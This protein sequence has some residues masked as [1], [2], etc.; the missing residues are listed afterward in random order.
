MSVQTLGGKESVSGELDSLRQQVD[1]EIAQTHAEH[2]AL[3]SF[4]DRLT[5][6]FELAPQATI[7]SSIATDSPEEQC[8]RSRVAE[9]SSAADTI[10]A[11]RR[12]YQETVMGL[13][14]YENEYGDSYGESL[15]AEFGE[16]IA[17]ALTQ[18]ACFTSAV[19]ASLVEQIEIALEERARL[20]GICY[21]E[22]E[23]LS[24]VREEL[25]P[26][27]TECESIASE[28]FADQPYTRLQYYRDRCLRLEERCDTIVRRRQQSLHR[29]REEYEF[30]GEIPTVRSYLYRD[31]GA[32]HP[33]LALCSSVANQVAVTRD[34]VE[35]A[36]AYCE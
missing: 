25:V 24:M 10:A 27:A 9:A 28:T 14:F 1:T 34:G 4:R 33:V 12:A 7:H 26:V 18:P 31:S 22:Q 36:I 8:L 17:I 11:I 16:E 20:L 19:R 2:E 29:R 13:S 23:S 30:G 5:E 35:Q 6:I 32:A 3:Q 15:R 21:E